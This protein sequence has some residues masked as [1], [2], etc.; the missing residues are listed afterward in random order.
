[1][2]V[3]CRKMLGGCPSKNSRHFLCPKTKMAGCTN[4]NRVYIQSQD[5]LF[6]SENVDSNVAPACN[7]IQTTNT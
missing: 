2:D 4:L 5:S 1:M 6:G 3:W 7:G